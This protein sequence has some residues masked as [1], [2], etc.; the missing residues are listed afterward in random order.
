MEGRGHLLDEGLDEGEIKDNQEDDGNITLN[1]NVQMCWFLRTSAANNSPVSCDVFK[2]GNRE[3]TLSFQK[4]GRVR[5][6]RHQA[7]D[8][9]TKTLEAPLSITLCVVSQPTSVT[10]SE[11]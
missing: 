9:E 7:P 3:I 2:G 5:L 10:P 11:K 4:V 1:L 8:E 6:H